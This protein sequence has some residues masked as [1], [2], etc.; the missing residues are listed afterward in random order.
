MKLVKFQIGVKPSSYG[1]SF[2]LD[3]LRYDGLHPRRSE[4]ANRIDDAGA[5]RSDEVIS[6]EGYHDKNWKPEVERW[7][8]FG[9]DV[10]SVEKAA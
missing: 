6:L 7:K 1:Y 4:D 10:V 9:W 3:M 2:P 5:R 8:S